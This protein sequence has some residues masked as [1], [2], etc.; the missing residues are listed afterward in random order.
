MNNTLYKNWRY[1][2]LLNLALVALVGVLMRYK[3]VAPLPELAQHNLMHGHSFFAFGAWASMAIFYQIITYFKLTIPY[4]NRWFTWYY[5]GL[6]VCLIALVLFGY[7]PISLLSI[8]HAEIPLFALVFLLFKSIANIQLLPKIALKAGLIYL[9]VAQLGFLFLSY[10]MVYPVGGQQ[11][12]LSTLYFYL[13]FSYNGWFFFGIFSLV[14][15]LIDRKNEGTKKEKSV[16]RAIW[17]MAISA[18]PAYLL[19]LLWLKIGLIYRII[20]GLSAFLQL[21]AFLFIALSI[22]KTIKKNIHLKVTKVLWLFSLM[23][24]SIKLLLQ[25][26]S[27]FPL[28]ETI[29]F[30]HRAIIIGYIHLVLLGFVTLFLI[31]NF[32]QIKHWVVTTTKARIAL[33]IVVVGILLNELFLFLQGLSALTL[34]SFSAANFYL[35]CIALSILIGIFAFYVQQLKDKIRP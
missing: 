20:A 6:L 32:I 22:F 19:S 34:K 2:I 7:S 16:L 4:I 28:F 13:H 14:L 3:I 24:L 25:T 1:I 5:F 23:A 21:F 35:F 15:G 11:I 12:Y 30:A 33:G 27:V 9:I 31:G 29:A 10:R 8:V 18:A 17:V 26:F